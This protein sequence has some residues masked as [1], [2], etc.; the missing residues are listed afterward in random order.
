MN[1]DSIGPLVEPDLLGAVYDFV[2]DC[3]RPTLD[4]D[5]V[6]IGWQNRTSLPDD[7]N[8]FAVITDLGQSRQ[9]TQIQRFAADPAV[10]E[11]GLAT[12]LNLVKAEVRVDFCAEDEAA[13][14]RASSLSILMSGPQAVEYFQPYGICALYASDIRDDSYTDGSN[15]YVRRFYVLLYL[16]YWSS[17][18]APASW[19][20]QV[21]PYLENVD[22]H[23]PQED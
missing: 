19:F 13:R 23:H 7:D 9:G 18:S 20:D 10:R 2:V 17:L 22:V 16:S 1:T 15:Q 5:R 21:D 6:F 8:N 14:H 3:A 11:D 4:P 12:W